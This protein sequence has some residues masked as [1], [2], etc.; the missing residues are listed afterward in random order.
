MNL[1]YLGC[2]GSL[3]DSDVRTIAI[4]F[5]ANQ[6]LALEG[7]YAEENCMSALNLY[8]LDIGRFSD[9]L[10]RVALVAGLA[11]H[12][13][14]GLATQRTGFLGFFRQP[15]GRWRLARILTVHAQLR[16]ECIHTREQG[17]NQPVLVGLGQLLQVEAWWFRRHAGIGNCWGLDR[18]ADQMMNFL[19]ANFALEY[20]LQNIVVDAWIEIGY[21]EFDEMC[22]LA[23]S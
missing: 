14:I 23:A 12:R 16:F 13:F 5:C 1:A 15:I 21:I 4:T 17:I 8:S 7:K 18:R 19:L 11:V 6:T 22:E 20:C 10:E 9:S 2:D 3:K